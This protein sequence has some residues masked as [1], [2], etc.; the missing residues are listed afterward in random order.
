SLL[1]DIG[2][3]SG[4]SVDL[5]ILVDLS[6]SFNDD[7]DEFRVDASEL[8]NTLANQFD[9]KVGLGSFVDYPIS[10]FG[11]EDL[12]YG[13]YAYKR[14]IDLTSDIAAVTSFIEDTTNLQT[15]WGQDGPESQLAALYQAATGAGQTVA[16]YPGASISAGQNAHFRDGVVKLFLVWTD[17]G[18]H[19]PGDSGDIPYPG[20]SFDD[21]VDAILALDPPQV[22]SVISGDNFDAIADA[23]AM[24]EDTNAFAPEG[25]VDCDDDGIIDIS[26]GEP[27]VCTTA[28][29]GVGIGKA[30][31]KVVT[32][33][34]EAGTPVARCKDVTVPADSDSCSTVVSI[35]DGSFDPDEGVLTLT[36]FPVGPYSVGETTVTLKVADESGRYDF[37]EATVTVEDITPPVVVTQNITV[38]LDTDGNASISAA[39]IDDGSGDNCGIASMSVAPSSFTCENIGANNTVTLTVTDNNGNDSTA[40]A[41]ITVEDNTVPTIEINAPATIIP[42]DA[43]ISF[44][45]TAEDNCSVEVEITDY[46][47]Y[48]IKKDGSQQSKMDGCAVSLSGDTVSI[49]DSGGV[50]DNITWTILATDQSG[51]SRTAEG[52][53]LVV[54]P[55]ESKK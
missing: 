17:A 21:T 51:N 29:T 38:Q 32:A 36:Q 6:S 35:D 3:C 34:I 13:D 54:T 45:A 2:W 49:A 47:C 12:I 48:K 1:C 23:E 18:F 20:P 8:I 11:G 44:T 40:S 41:S 33:A 52:H 43:P 50:N 10:P 24:A 9:L 14:E 53:V 26:E 15:H 4:E 30:I 25:G 16:G 46:F 55:E 37:C 42:P 28:A 31:E 7:I 19:L 39:D 5:F 22:L 27:I